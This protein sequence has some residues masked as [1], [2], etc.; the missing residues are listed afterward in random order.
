MLKVLKKGKTVKFINFIM[1]FLAMKKHNILASVLVLLFTSQ[2]LMKAYSTPIEL[3]YDDG[4][5]DYG[6][7]NFYPYAAAVKFSPPSASWKIEAIRIHAACFIK[8]N[9]IFYVQIWDKNLNTIYSS[10]FYLSKVFK[11]ATLDWYTV[12]LPSVVVSG[13]FYL[14]VVPMFT[15]DGS[16]LWIS[17]DKDFPIS[18]NSYIVDASTHAILLNLNSTSSKPGNFMLRAVGEPSTLTPEIKLSSVE[19]NENYTTIVFTYLGEPRSLGAR[20]I[21]QDGSFVEL[22]VTRSGENLIVKVGDQGTLNVFVVTQNSEIVG[23]SVR[24]EDKL[25]MLYKSLLTNYTVLKEKLYE[26]NEKINSLEKEND[27]FKSKLRDSGYVI[28]ILEKQVYELTDNVTKQSQEISK[29]NKDVE[30][31]QNENKIL[32]AVVVLL[33]AFLVIKKFGLKK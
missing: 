12:E 24:V 7:S 33:V 11:N 18:N 25:R 23:T 20:L 3:S 5:F 13:D 16:Q 8:G 28:N 14:V 31:L 2:F 27:D 26:A 10:S 15:L 19:V 6:W 29:L 32:L 17:V 30:G 22:N 4:E 21:K 9:E 1:A